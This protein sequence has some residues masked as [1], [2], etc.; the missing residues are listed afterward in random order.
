[1]YE[2]RDYQEASANRVLECMARRPI[3]VLPTGAGKTVTAATIVK[4]YGVRTLWLAHRRELI[5]QAARSLSRIGLTTGV[6]LAGRQPTPAAQVQVASVQTLIRRDFPRAGLVVIDEAHHACGPSY[7]RIVNNYPGVPI[8]GLTA[9]PFRL[10]GKGLRQAG[11]A[12]IVVG[13][14]PAELCE[15]GVLHE[16]TVYAPDRPNTKGLRIRA[17]DF[18]QDQAATLMSAPRLVGRVVETWLNRAAGRRTV[19][20]TVNVAHSIALMERFREA[21]VRCEHV[22]GTTPLTERAEIL[23]RLASAETTVL[24]NCQVL[25]EG[26][27]LPA[28]EVAV[29]ARPT[30]SLNLHLQMIGRIMRSCAEKDGAVVLDHAGNHHR[31]G[32]VTDHIEY[33]LDSKISKGTGQ[34]RPRHCPECTALVPP[35]RSACPACGYEYPYSQVE[36]PA[37]TDG[38][39]VLIKGPTI[40]PHQERASYYAQMRAIADRK[41]AVP[42]GACI[43]AAVLHP[44]CSWCESGG[45]DAEEKRVADGI[46][47]AEAMAAS[48]FQR[49]YKEW[50]IVVDGRLFNPDATTPE[51]LL[52]L[53][54]AW[55]E[56][57][58]RMARR[59]SKPDEAGFARW[60]VRQRMAAVSRQS[61]V[62]T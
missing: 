55:Y 4:R 61:G 51:Q 46:S 22:D 13:A 29:L 50:P 41:F 15:R 57:G 12:E 56:E 11:F 30:A 39:L 28:L 7:R 58:V 36:L 59:K 1:M 24:C 10:D 42:R 3:L 47:K 14:R 19:V 38:E 26:W 43:C 6:I 54:C 35:G 25:T 45:A 34:S 20:F 8:L 18:A 52:Q 17:G 31:L 37:E 49:K 48:A 60:F 62:G 53:R 5:D 16:P 44:P 21:G 33:S 32:M 23:A 27:D 2:L 40:S 9:T